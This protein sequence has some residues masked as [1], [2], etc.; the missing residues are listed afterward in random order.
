MKKL[1]TSPPVLSQ[2]ANVNAC[3]STILPV[4][5]RLCLAGKKV[6]DDNENSNNSSQWCYW[7]VYVR[8]AFFISKVWKV[9]ILYFVNF[10]IYCFQFLHSIWKII[11]DRLEI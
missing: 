5:K 2:W 10:S 6:R 11:P 1:P 8:S 3:S 4:E 7:L 9:M